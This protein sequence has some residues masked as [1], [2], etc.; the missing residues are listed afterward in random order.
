MGM[1]A[2]LSQSILDKITSREVFAYNLSD[3]TDS[4]DISYAMMRFSATTKEQREEEGM[5]VDIFSWEEELEKIGTIGVYKK[6]KVSELNELT[7]CDTHQKIGES[8]D[9]AYEYYIST[10]SKGNKELLA[11]L[12]KSEVTISEMHKIDANLGYNAF[13]TDRIDDVNTVGNFSTK[14]IFGNTYTQD[15]F[16]E[17]DLTLVNVFTTWCSPCVEEIPELEKLRQEYEKKNIKL[18]VVGVVLDVETKNGTDEGALERAQ[19]LYK[20]SEAQFP[21]LIP[22]EG[23]MNGRLTGIESFPESF[24]VDKNGNIVSDPYI[25]ANSK[26]QWSKII[27]KE[28]ANLKGNN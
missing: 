12:E 5:S 9:G 15:V 1:T 11:E 21:F 25:G 6:D 13:S 17:N 24:F 20:K 7:A 19:T 27:D 22:D 23:N 26:D 18:G 16:K 8:T 4:Y 14:D 10:N 2:K 3:Y 28:L